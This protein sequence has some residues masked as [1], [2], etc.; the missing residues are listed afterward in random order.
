MF[1][2]SG[3]ILYEKSTD[4]IVYVSDTNEHFVYYYKY[5]RN[6][7]FMVMH[8]KPRSEMSSFFRELPHE[9]TKILL[10]S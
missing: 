2:R 1:Y 6:D 3:Q 5:C 9:I 4:E 10:L 8:D 7:D